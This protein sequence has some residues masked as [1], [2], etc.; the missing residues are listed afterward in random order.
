MLVTFFLGIL[1]PA[2]ES[3]H[4]SNLRHARA[5]CCWLGVSNDRHA[6]TYKV[7]FSGSCVIWTFKEVAPQ[8]RLVECRDTAKATLLTLHDQRTWAGVFPSTKNRCLHQV[9][10]ARRLA[11]SWMNP[12]NGESLW[13]RLGS[14]E[15]QYNSR[16]HLEGDEH[17][18]SIL[19]EMHWSLKCV[20]SPKKRYVAWC[21]KL[22]PPG[23][24]VASMTDMVY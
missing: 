18:C 12:Q 4:R 17:A 22:C 14:M 8:V 21:A 2:D 19:V 7:R 9:A 6:V 24:A 16:R 23:Q 20:K 11:A 5:V 3:G 13:R 15:T 10:E 1:S